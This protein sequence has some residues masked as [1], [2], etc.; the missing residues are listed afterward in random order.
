MYSVGSNFV[1]YYMRILVRLI[2][3]VLII[4]SCYFLNKTGYHLVNYELTGGLEPMTF[5]YGRSYRE[6][7]AEFIFWLTLAI[8]G[9]ALSSLRSFGL[10]IGFYSLL[11]PSVVC[12]LHLIAS[13]SRKS[14]YSTTLVV[15]TEGRK[16]TLAEQW[17]YIYSEPTLL[18]VLTIAVILSLI[19]VRKLIKAQRQHSN[20]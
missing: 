18:F 6:I 5:G 13:I 7:V 3:G 8:G 15:N 10:K 19:S 20:K 2:G 4:V 14:N 12:L 17:K 9:V 1:G 16:M 11:I